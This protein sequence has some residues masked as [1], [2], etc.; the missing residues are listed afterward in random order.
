MKILHIASIKN[1]PF[2]GVCVV[3][4]QHIIYQGKQVDVALLNIQKCQID[5]IQH[6]FFYEGKNWKH[7][8][9][10][11]F[12][13]PDIV[14]FHE[15]YHIEFAKM[16]RTLVKQC[17]PYVIV[18]HGCLT[19]VAQGQK[20]LKK[21]AANFLFFNQFIKYSSALQCLSLNEKE[22]T[23]FNIYKFIGTNG[24]HIPDTFKNDFGK[25]P[26]QVSYIGRLDPHHKGIDLLIEAIC[27]EESFLRKNNVKID[28]YGP[29]NIAE[30]YN[31]LKNEIQKKKLEDFVTLHHAVMG[32]EKK[33]VLLKS[34]LFIQTSRYEGMPMGILEALSYGVPC[35]ITEGTCL[36][37]IV[38]HY[39][40]GWVAET[41]IE[42]I[43]KTI[44]LAI[45]EKSKLIEKSNNARRLVKE[46]YSWNIVAS[47]IIN[48]YKHIVNANKHE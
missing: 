31:E 33:Q 41:T 35:I 13:K 28:F 21:I 11:E 16:A 34:D 8:V 48:D 36:G 27:Q 47:N 42:S 45:N 15:V 40:A 1:N 17:I 12:Q 19:T 43:A 10:L 4:P 39:D 38:A 2:N 22:N 7:D 6:Q 46:N 20:R 5:G 29:D 30:W 37:E 26:I 18:P 14:V 44:E 25:Y 23:L 24:I 32:D 3:V 9:S